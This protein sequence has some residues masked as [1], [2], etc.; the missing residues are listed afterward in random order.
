MEASSVGTLP[1]RSSHFSRFRQ[2]PPYALLACILVFAMAPRFI[3]A[4]QSE[5]QQVYVDTGRQLRNGEAMYGPAQPYVYPPFMAAA[6]TPFSYFSDKW[7]RALWLLSNA[8]ALVACVRSAWILAGGD[9]RLPRFGAPRSEHWIVWLGLACGGYYIIDALGHQQTDLVIA[10]LLMCGCL[11]VRE[12]RSLLGGVLLGIAAGCKCTPLLFAPYLVWRGRWLASAV[13]LVTAVG[14]NL[15]PDLIHA[16][17]DGLWLV[18]WWNTYIAPQV[19]GD[20]LP[21]VWASEVIYNQSLAGALNRWTQT[22][23]QWETSAVVVGP[24]SQ[25][26]PPV[27]LKQFLRGLQ[28]GIVIAAAVVLLYRPFRRLEQPD[29]EKRFAPECS[30]IFVLML[31]LSPMSSKP[32]FCTLLL[33]GFCLAR[34]FITLKKRGSLVFVLGAAILCGLLA[35]KDLVKARVYTLVLWYGL[36]TISAMLLGVGCGVVLL[37]NRKAAAFR[38]GSEQPLQK[39]AA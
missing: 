33:P 22:T 2:I 30:I 29:G 37:R 34:G 39:V 28:L 15:L 32:H 5:W 14:I 20:A 24:A 27:E 26:L 19:R 16:P 3:F 21:G 4:K 38:Q 1:I 8:I 25:T 9:R 6:A 7:S 17:A 31:L 10:A 12:E 36:V 23:W 13:L 18:H 11:A 35:N